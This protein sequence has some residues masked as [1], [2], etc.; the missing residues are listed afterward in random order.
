[1][2]YAPRIV[3]I[4]HFWRSVLYD[5][6]IVPGR[7]SDTTLGVPIG[8]VSNVIFPGQVS[9]SQ[10]ICPK[11][12][13]LGTSTALL[14]NHLFSHTWLLSIFG[15]SFTKPRNSLLGE[16]GEFPP[17]EGSSLGYDLLCRCSEIHYPH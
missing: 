6:L 13:I 11:T 3:G 8:A 1:M 10:H 2:G 9:D 16:V 12:R 5:V 14:H 15:M 4:Y 17:L 7:V